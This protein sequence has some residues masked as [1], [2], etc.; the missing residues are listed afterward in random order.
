M[1]IVL[2]VLFSWGVLYGQ[3]V[4]AQ[5]NTVTG[6]VAYTV[7]LQFDYSKD[8]VRNNVQFW[9]DFKGSP[10]LG[11]PDEAGYQPESG[12]VYYYLVDVDNK[13]KVDNWLMGFS[14]MEGPPP[15]GPYPMTD[16]IITGNT[17]RFS[18][19]GKSWTVVDGGDGYRNDTITIND[20]FSTREM[21]LFGGDMKIVSTEAKV[22]VSNTECVDCHEGKSAEMVAQGGKHV[23]LSCEECHIGHPPEEQHSYT[24]CME[25]HE[26]HSGEMDEQSCSLCHQAH[27]ASEVV[28]GY[29]VPSTY[30]SSCHKEAAYIL[31]SS[32][33]KHS[34]IDCV[35]CHQEKHTDSSSCLFCHGGSHPDHVMKNEDICASCHATAHA[36]ESAR[37][38]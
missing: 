20:G 7:V 3:A 35:R 2:A 1:K 17:A 19:F 34:D 15:S 9:L 14:M 38:K 36:L 37:E 16:I 33:S 31:A 12:A 6:A 32:R 5:P 27:T 21:G 30:C 8:G 26:P 28:Y 4:A 25:C 10:A 29:D 18:A 23:T 13:K 22:S 24:G 11:D